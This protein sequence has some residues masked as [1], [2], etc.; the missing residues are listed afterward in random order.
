MA[1]TQQVGRRVRALRLDRG[2]TQA[3][4]AEAADLTPD[5]V[6][7]IERGTREPR[8]ATLDRL[9]RALHVAAKDLFDEDGETPS[10][11]T[12][13]DMRLAEALG[14]VHPSVADALVKSVRSIARAVARSHSRKRAPRKP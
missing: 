10:D 11:V 5:E 7:R 9:S 3:S 13:A 1:L 14:G 6:S 4:L 12:P 8:F 2:M